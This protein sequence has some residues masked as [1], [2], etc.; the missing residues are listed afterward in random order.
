MRKTKKI[1][2]S[3]LSV[4]LLSNYVTIIS[5]AHGDDFN[6]DKIADKISDDL[7]IA[8]EENSEDIPV[9]IWLKSIESPQIEMQIKNQIGF[10]VNGIES[11]YSAPSNELLNE[12]AKASSGEPDEYLR[13][14]MDNHLE[15]TE[16]SRKI[17]KEKTDLYLETKRKLLSNYYISQANSFLDDMDISDDCV[18]FISE[19][20]PM[21]ICN[22]SSDAIQSVAE[23]SI[24]EAIS[25]HQEIEE[26]LFTLDPD[27]M[28][29]ALNSLNVT[30]VGQNLGL[31]GNGVKIGIFEAGVVSKATC[32]NYGVDPSRVTLLGSPQVTDDHPT[33]IAGI[34]AG[35]IGVAPGSLIYS[36]SS[37]DTWVSSNQY[38]DVNHRW[39]NLETMIDCGVTVFN[40][41]F[42]GTTEINNNQG[43]NNMYVEVSKYLDYLIEDTGIT[44]V[45]ADGNGAD[46]F[47]SNVASAFNCISVNGYGC[48]IPETTTSEEILNNYSYATGTGC[49]KPDVISPSLNGGT[50]NSAPFICG[51]ISLLYQYKPALQAHPEVVKSILMASCHRKCSRLY[52]DANNIQNLSETMAQGLTDRQGAGIPDIYKMISIVAQHSYGFGELNS[53]NGYNRKVNI[54]QPKYGAT[55]M[56]VSMAYLHT[57]VPINQP[58]LCDNYCLSLSN[59][60]YSVPI[61]SD[62]PVSSTEMIYTDLSNNSKYELEI[63]KNSGSMSNV[64]YGYAWSTDNTSF[65]PYN[66]EE[67]IYVLKNKKSE[68][69]LSMNDS[70]LNAYQ[71]NYSSSNN[72][73]WI[74]KKDIVSGNYSLMSANGNDKNLE[75]GNN[76][77]GSYYQATGSNTSTAMS[78]S[79]NNDGSYSFNRIAQSN[80]FGLG[81]L[82][83]STSSGAAAS[84]SPYNSIND[85]QHWYLEAVEYKKGDVNRDGVISAVDA[86]IVMDIYSDIATQQDTSNNL[87]KFL[88][89]YD[90]NGHINSN[91]ASA[92]LSNQT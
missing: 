50:S 2:S 12:L 63:K 81:I 64:K 33:T 44:I 38:P 31:N 8:M 39:E 19:Y 66:N 43:I 5:D 80:I 61:E 77:S 27:D 29:P 34:A 40:F 86:S 7:Q 69:Y 52:I 89:D 23:N 32:L 68:K 54:L 48:N 47:V 92:I 24:V 3:L 9:T 57:N 53:G 72:Q 59:A 4:V 71:S 22:I 75:I 78:L 41:S 46:N 79:L 65:Y 21:I 58:S 17:E 25:F 76:Q 6:R 74:L 56:N 42:G 87:D 1:V 28:P 73:L 67:G 45:C 55:K 70:T 13:A 16:S 18:S 51:I 36:A 62:M 82:N 10:D 30:Q 20:A 83:N 91:D 37:E 35:T 88:A 60:N 15:L 90:N 26:E 85:S 84:W 11:S 49:I 14:L